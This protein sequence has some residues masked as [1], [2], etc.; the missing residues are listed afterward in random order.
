MFNFTGFGNNTQCS[1]FLNR[2][3]PRGWYRFGFLVRSFTPGPSITAWFV[4]SAI[5]FHRD[6]C[7]VSKKFFSQGAK[8][9]RESEQASQKE[10]ERWRE[11][12]RMTR[13]F[14]PST[15][16]WCVWASKSEEH[17][18]FYQNKCICHQSLM[19]VWGMFGDIRYRY[20]SVRVEVILVQGIFSAI[21]FS[22]LMAS[23]PPTEQPKI[24]IWLV[25][26]FKSKRA[27]KSRWVE[28]NSGGFRSKAQFRVRFGCCILG[29]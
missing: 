1:Q 28:R 26:G 19:V 22:D 25:Q 11:K 29:L 12:E 7:L 18:S 5:S 10:R 2:C 20:A 27:S 9:K 13:Q 23:W 17:G 24:S 4:A 14:N 21:Y 16:I 15:N 3:L 6:C 8:C